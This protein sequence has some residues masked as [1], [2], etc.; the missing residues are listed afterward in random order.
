M[1]VMQKSWLTVS[2]TRTFILS[3]G[4]PDDDRKA[5]LPGLARQQGN[6]S[7]R[8]H[9]ATSHCNCLLVIAKYICQNTC[10]E[11]LR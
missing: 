9:M 6:I 2:S 5:W 1:P 10:E 3:R 8:N 4:L 11:C 7:T